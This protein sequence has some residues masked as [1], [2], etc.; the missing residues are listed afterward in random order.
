MNVW[1]SDGDDIR[2]R[3]A[4]MNVILSF[5]RCFI[6]SLMNNNSNIVFARSRVNKK[7]AVHWIVHI[8]VAVND[9]N[10]VLV[11]SF[12]YMHV[13]IPTVYFRPSIFPN[14]RRNKNRIGIHFDDFGS[15]INTFTSAHDA[16]PSNLPRKNLKNNN[17]IRVCVDRRHAKERVW[18]FFFSIIWFPIRMERCENDVIHARGFCFSRFVN[19]K[20]REK[21]TNI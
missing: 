16:N 20:M 4:F 6:M 8:V 14:F 3:I 12:F 7:V 11:H 5:H 2:R 1:I 17:H 13:F 21:I 18:Y 9:F 10:S 15:G 19:K